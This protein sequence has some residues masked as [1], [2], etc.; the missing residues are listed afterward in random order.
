[1]PEGNLRVIDPEEHPR[2]C[3]AD[4]QPLMQSLLATLADIDFEHERELDKMKNSATDALLKE[5]MI[6]KLEQR[7]RE[8][9]H[10]YVQE[11]MALEARMRLVLAQSA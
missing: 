4:V 3:P 9:R 1:M 5:R 7:H 2:V 11:L 10:P 6:K 8:R